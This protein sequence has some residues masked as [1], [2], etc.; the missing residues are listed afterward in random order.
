MA[1]FPAEF[2][3]NFDWGKQPPPA[4]AHETH[5]LH[6]WLH[7][8]DA[9]VYQGLLFYHQGRNP[10]SPIFQEQNAIE[11]KGYLIPN[12]PVCDRWG[13][14]TYPWS[15]IGVRVS[16]RTAEEHGGHADV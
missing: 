12:P 11:G 13:T 3:G 7:S 9:F 4:Q 8:P 15:W 2:K 5:A 6:F 14:P 10:R 1:D 16:F